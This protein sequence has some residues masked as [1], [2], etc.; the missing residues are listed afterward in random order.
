MK[1]KPM[2]NALALTLAFTP[3]LQ[4]THRCS[5]LKYF[6]QTLSAKIKFRW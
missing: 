5:G 4:A 1:E 3:K 2:H 6:L